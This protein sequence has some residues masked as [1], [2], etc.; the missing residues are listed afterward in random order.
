MRTFGIFWLSTPE[1][2]IP[3]V[4]LQLSRFFYQKVT[5]KAILLVMMNVIDIAKKSRGRDFITMENYFDIAAR[6]GLGYVE[7]DEM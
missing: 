6:A 4:Q 7:L 2:S 1:Q 3:I 5:K